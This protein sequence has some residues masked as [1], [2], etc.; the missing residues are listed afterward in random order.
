MSKFI[1]PCCIGY[2]LINLNHV[3][4]GYSVH[5]DVIQLIS[6]MFLLFSEIFVIES[7]IKWFNRHENVV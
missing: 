6:H 1:L 3:I 5:D 7:L 2:I 4:F